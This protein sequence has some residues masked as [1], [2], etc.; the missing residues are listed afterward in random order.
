MFHRR[1]ASGLT[2]AAFVILMAGS[3]APAQRLS[4]RIQDYKQRQRDAARDATRD[5]E[6]EAERTGQRTVVAKLRDVID[7]VVVE[8]A[9]AQKAF[10]WWSRT[11]Q[12]PI[13]INWVKLEELGI[14]PDTRINLNLRN[15]SAGQLLA[16]LMKHTSLDEPLL[17]EVTPWYVEILTK[18]QANSRTVVRIY[19]VGDLVMDIPNFSETPQFDLSAALDREDVGGGGGGGESRLF[20]DYERDDDDTRDQRTNELVAMIRETIEPDIWQA[21]GGQ[22]ASIRIFQR[23]LIVNAPLYVHAQIGFKAV[24]TRQF[25]GMTKPKKLREDRPSRST[26]NSDADPVSGVS[27]T[28]STPVSGVR[29]SE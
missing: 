14:N 19:D 26:T 13:V 4:D 15:I 25:G 7:P 9:P 11:A 1:F 12:I 16:L 18:Q 28:E 17:Y 22:Y 27:K 21:H 23:R 5:A 3:A 24:G 29:R 8:N 10:E 6:K 2:L 20:G